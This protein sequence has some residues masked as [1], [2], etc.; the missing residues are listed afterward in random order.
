MR[1]IL[2]LALAVA[3]L[4]P[5]PSRAQHAP[6]Q[7]PAAM[8]HGA[9]TIEGAVVRASI[10]TAP[11]SAAYMRITNSGAPDRLV[12]AASPAARAVELHASLQEAGVSKMQRV[13]AVPVAADAPAELAPGGHHLMLIGLAR[14]LEDGT[15]IP[16]TL[17]FEKAGEVTLDVPVS[18]NIA[19]HAH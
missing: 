1:P 3:V 7:A 6:T 9:L 8:T 17:T 15:T 2:M 12:A 19:A 10:G 16:L 4:L 5:L 13:D 11:T 18:K 14:P